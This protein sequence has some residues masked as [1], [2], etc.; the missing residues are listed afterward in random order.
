MRRQL[1]DGQADKVFSLKSWYQP[2]RQQRQELVWLVNNGSDF[3]LLLLR[4]ARNPTVSPDGR[5]VAYEF[6]KIARYG[7]LAS[8]ITNLHLARLQ[9]VP[10]RVHEFV[11]NRGGLEGLKKGMILHVRGSDEWKGYPPIGAVQVVQTFPHRAVVRSVIEI[12]FPYGTDGSYY[13][14]KPVEAG[15]RVIIPGSKEETV[16]LDLE[17]LPSSSNSIL[18]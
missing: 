5:W 10:Q 1:V 7:E 4:N 15:D 17:T 8:S 16:L 9:E 6:H 13:F 18:R 14:G 2:E 3:A 12:D 11:L